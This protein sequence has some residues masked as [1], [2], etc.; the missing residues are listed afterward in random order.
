MVVMRS[1]KMAGSKRAVS[2][3]RSIAR[4]TRH[5]QPC[6]RSFCSALDNDRFD[7]VVVPEHVV[8]P[9]LK[10]SQRFGLQIMERK[11]HS[12]PDSGTCRALNGNKRREA[13]AAQKTQDVFVGNSAL[14]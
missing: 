10:Q 11:Q 12:R 1:S 8:N 9:G 5:T 7:H 4:V 14:D 13:I 6:A 3:S 2:H